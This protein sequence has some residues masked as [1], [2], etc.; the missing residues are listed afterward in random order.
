M[1]FVIFVNKKEPRTLTHRMLSKSSPRTDLL[2]PF[3]KGRLP[4]EATL[5]LR[6]AASGRAGRI[7]AAVTGAAASQLNQIESY[8]TGV[9]ERGRIPLPLFIS[10][11]AVTGCGN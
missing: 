3:E 2:L 9:G 4:E 6:E 7:K 11:V 8:G 10:M 1:T 5:K